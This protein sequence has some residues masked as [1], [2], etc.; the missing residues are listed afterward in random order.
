[1]YY[2]FNTIGK[3]PIFF[4]DCDLQDRKLGFE[5]INLESQNLSRD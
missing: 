2:L 4:L 1:M 3:S 5:I